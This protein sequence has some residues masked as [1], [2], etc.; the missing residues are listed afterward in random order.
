MNGKRVFR[1]VRKNG[2]G[3]VYRRSDIGEVCDSWKDEVFMN[4][5]DLDD[6]VLK[7]TSLDHVKLILNYITEPF[8]K[9]LSSKRITTK[10]I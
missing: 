6:N 1:M 8:T 10:F 4:D 7:H 5:V 9:S 2:V 3:N